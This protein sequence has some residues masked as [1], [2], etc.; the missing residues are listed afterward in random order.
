[1]AIYSCNLSSIGKTT[2]AAGTAGAHISYIGRER[3]ASEILCE[4][5]P[6][7]PQD[8]RT[9]MDH[10]EANARRN[11]RVC[12]KI[13]VALPIELDAMQRAELVHEF[14]A[15]LT[16]G[17][18]P[19]YAAIH[20]DGKDVHNPHAH[21]VIRDKSI[22]DGKRVVRLS[23]SPRDR[24]KAGLEPK[25]VDHVRERWEHFAN[26]ALAS[27][28]HDERVDRR[29]LEAQGI[30][31]KAT[32]HIGPRAN[33]IDRT[34]HRPVSQIR[35]TANGRSIDYPLIDAGRTRREFNAEI[36]DFNLE[37]A[38]RSPDGVTRAWAKFEKEQRDLDRQVDQVLIT[39]ARRRTI[40][41]RRLKAGFKA[42]A[43]AIRKTRHDERAAARA[44]IRERYEAPLAEMKERHD[45]KRN[46]LRDKH[47]RLAYRIMAFLDFSGATKRKA[48]TAEGKLEKDL[49]HERQT[50]SETISM[51][52]AAQLEAVN[53]RFKAQFDE[54][55]MEK[56]LRLG[57]QRE[58]T[59]EEHQAEQALLQERETEREQAKARL[60]R[61]LTAFAKENRAQRDAR[62]RNFER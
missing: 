19:W 40:E 52:R 41:E 42:R 55:N 14:M 60:E 54:L 35:Q 3:A 32:I 29:T 38:A 57:Q 26:A 18:V 62:N 58:A 48:Q 16:K 25:A 59:R 23:D 7:T 53:A 12:S 4:H 37:K 33:V 47:S 61:A 6:R 27:A 28:G 30:D 43:D 56:Q 9:W 24:Q 36:M 2:H 8:A 11:A 50:V 10:E 21:I 15:G 34:V 22:V 39:G 51:T 1:M 5:M 20:Q 46:E 45:A 17:Q 49:A 13:R 31:R 44:F